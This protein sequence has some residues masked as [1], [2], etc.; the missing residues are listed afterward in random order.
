MP[1]N[2]PKMQRKFNNN[3]TKMQWKCT[4]NAA[5]MQPTLTEIGP[6]NRPKD[7]LKKE[8]EWPKKWTENETK[9]KRF[10]TYVY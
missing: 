1:E 9:L 5:K 8:K 4:E 7:G 6:E 3:S 2:E 10:R